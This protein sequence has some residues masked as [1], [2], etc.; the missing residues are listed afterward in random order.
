MNITKLF[1]FP[2][3]LVLWTGCEKP[4]Q[5]PALRT[6]IKIVSARTIDPRLKE[7]VTNMVAAYDRRY[8]LGFPLLTVVNETNLKSGVTAFTVSQEVH[9]NLSVI[10][11]SDLTNVLAHEFF[12]TLP[13]KERRTITEGVRLGDRVYTNFHGLSLVDQEL[14]DGREKGF[15]AFEEGV[16]EF[17]AFRF[18]PGYSSTA[19][20][21]YAL[22][23]LVQYMEHIGWFTVEDLIRFQKSNGVPEFCAAVLKKAPDVVT[24]DDIVFV[25]TAFQHVRDNMEN[26]QPELKQIIERRGETGKYQF[27]E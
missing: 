10:S 20:D 1:L 23:K 6:N 8:T 4:L 13:P 22:G 14:V 7:V 15:I 5:Q 9:V 21:Y 16:A 19:P 18:Q 24:S 11:A 3:L 25:A 27:R 12:H 26:I 2:L 17:C